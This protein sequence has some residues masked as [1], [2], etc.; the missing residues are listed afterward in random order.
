MN[1]I[2]VLSQDLE[3]KYQNKGPKNIAVSEFKHKRSSEDE[4]GIAQIRNKLDLKH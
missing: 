3:F 1:S 4:M 2:N